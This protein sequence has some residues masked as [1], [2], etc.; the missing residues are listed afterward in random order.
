MNQQSVHHTMASV[1]LIDQ[2]ALKKKKNEADVTVP[3]AIKGWVPDENS[4]STGSM[5][6]EMDTMNVWVNLLAV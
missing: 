5:C 3:S 1:L 2:K 4:C 6:A